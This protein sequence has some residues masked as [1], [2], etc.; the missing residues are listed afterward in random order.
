M[1][2]EE[3]VKKSSGAIFNNS[4]QIWNHDFY[5]HGLSPEKKNPSVHFLKR[6]E[7]DF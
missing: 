1:S 2:L 4:A 5:W 6:I 7:E 3:I